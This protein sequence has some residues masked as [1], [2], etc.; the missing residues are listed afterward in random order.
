MTPTNKPQITENTVL[1]LIAPTASGKTALAYQLY[2][3]GDYELISVDSALIYNDMNIG[4]AK[5]SEQELLDYPHHL[6]N[7]MPPTAGYNVA[8][9]VSDVDRLIDEIHGRGKIPLLV[10][11]TMMYYMALFD[12]LSSVPN[13]ENAVRQQVEGWRQ[14]EGI[15]SLHDYLTKH[16]PSTAQRLNVSDTQRVT[17][18]VEVHKQ[19]GKPMSYWQALPKQALA[20][21][22]DNRH[23]QAL[24]VMPD[25][26]WLHDRIALRLDM[27]WADGFV[28]EVI[29]LI[30]HYPLNAT[31]PAMRCVGYRQVLDF[32]LQM[33]FVE[34]V[35]S[36]KNGELLKMTHN[37][38]SFDTKEISNTG[39]INLDEAC[40]DMKNKAL[41]ATRQLAK[42]Q[43][44]W[45]RKLTSG[46]LIQNNNM[47]RYNSVEEIKQQLICN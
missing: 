35:N 43:Y 39:D 30:N 15:E 20:K 34:S 41:Y 31:M 11:G 33:G 9:F 26:A 19:T 7:I 21:R 37:G 29:W 12:G 8:S 5:P 46:N 18:A 27:M 24:A 16:D 10:G 22:D 3:T 2:D 42:R 36:P 4:T 1:S 47:F 6:V 28:D 32:L 38:N 23:W 44:T 25:R 45:L 40:Q 13:T 17:R 14:A